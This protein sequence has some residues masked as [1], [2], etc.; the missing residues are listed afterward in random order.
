MAPAA[1]RSAG[2]AKPSRLA[3]ELSFYASYHHNPVNVALHAVFIPTIYITLYALLSRVPLPAALAPAG[4]ALS[5]A[6][7]WLAPPGLPGAPLALGVAGVFAVYYAALAGATPLG[8]A[9]FA[10]AGGL[11]AAGLHLSAAL[12]PA[13]AAPAAGAAHVVAWLAQFYGH[14]AHE[15]RAPALLTNLTQALVLAGA[16]VFIEAA[17]AAGALG[18]LRA[19]VEPLVE[20]R[21]AAFAAAEPAGRAA[22]KRAA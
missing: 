6:A 7:P 12:G 5:A 4:A 20:R 21:L 17:F 14:F 10:W 22:A 15:R 9:L 2:E 11:C 8:A 18:G 3:D 19:E 16:F 13:R 1:R